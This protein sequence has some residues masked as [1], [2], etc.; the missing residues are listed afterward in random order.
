MKEVTITIKIVKARVLSTP[1][2]GTSFDAVRLELDSPPGFSATSLPPLL[3]VTMKYGTGA[4][5]VR[6]TFGIEPEVIRL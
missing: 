6:D 3:S 1:C 2:L 5:W 4:D